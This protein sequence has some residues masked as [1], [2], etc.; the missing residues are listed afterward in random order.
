MQ[1]IGAGPSP[2]LMRA[3]WAGIRR[4][5]NDRTIFA[6]QRRG[7]AFIFN[8]MVKRSI[9]LD[10][11]FAALADPT[12]RRILRG[13]MRGCAPVGEIAS[14][15]RVSAPAVSRHL[16]VLERAGLI[17]RNRRG[18]IHEI[19]LAAAPMRAARDWLEAYRR[20]WEDSLEALA[21]YLETPAPAKISTSKTKPQKAK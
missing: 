5:G 16:R 17:R 14:P 15:F 2:V 9:S 3:A 18:R 10:T 1:N 11:V 20:H 7:T 21:R 6:W 13:L 4:V 8:A 19:E 12:R